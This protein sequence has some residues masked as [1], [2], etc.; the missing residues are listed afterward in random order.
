[1][2]IKLAFSLLIVLSVLLMGSAWNMPNAPEIWWYVLG[3]GG[4]RVT[5][6]SVVLEGTL[7]QSVAGT[8][9]QAPLEMCSGYWC[10]GVSGSHIYLP[11]VKKQ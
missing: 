11:M 5:N 7:G 8:V 4:G 2:K 6:G 3:G 1:M 9:S 10:G